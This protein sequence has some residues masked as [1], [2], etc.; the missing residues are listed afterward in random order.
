MVIGP[1]SELELEI[2][3]GFGGARLEV[4]GQVAEER[5]RSL[6]I[7]LREGVAT[8]VGFDGQEPLLAGLRR[9]R[10][11]IDSPRVSADAD[12]GSPSSPAVAD[13]GLSGR[14]PHAEPWSG[15]RRGVDVACTIGGTESEALHASA[16]RA[17]TEPPSR[18]EKGFDQLVHLP[19]LTTGP[20]LVTSSVGSAPAHAGPRRHPAVGSL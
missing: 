10:I 14:H 9:R 19:G 6:T 12:Q 18:R 7:S 5:A 3:P 8:M 20:G 15:A 4:D 16:F 11:I 17:E 13:H 1:G 2:R